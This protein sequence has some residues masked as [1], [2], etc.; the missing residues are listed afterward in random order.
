MT[1]YRN[2]FAVLCFAFFFAGVMTQ[3]PFA[4]LAAMFC[5]A[6]SRTAGKRGWPDPFLKSL[7]ST[8]FCTAILITF[9]INTEYQNV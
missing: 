5:G 3:A 1:F 2:V 7:N 6:L 4:F 8:A 9:F